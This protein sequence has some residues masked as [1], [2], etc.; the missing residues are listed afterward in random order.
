MQAEGIMT[1]TERI[2]EFLKSLITSPASPEGRRLRIKYLMER[3]GAERDVCAAIVYARDCALDRQ[4]SEEEV[5]DAERITKRLEK[6]EI[7]LPADRT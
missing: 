1:K 6:R 7:T 2:K 5:K 3:I 4:F